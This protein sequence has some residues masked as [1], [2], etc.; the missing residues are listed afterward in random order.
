MKKHLRRYAM[1]AMAVGAMAGGTAIAQQQ[2]AVP[3]WHPVTYGLAETPAQ[4]LP[5]NV[6][7]AQPVRVVST[8]LDATGRPVVT[9]HTATDTAA[10]TALV[11]KAQQAP[12][13]VGV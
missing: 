9:V 10:A 7:T 11:K 3:Y 8:T 13:A 6:S 5:A 4:L 1:G 12:R 2:A